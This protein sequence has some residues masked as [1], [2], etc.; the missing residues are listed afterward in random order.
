MYL[1]LSEYL[2]FLCVENSAPAND[3]ASLAPVDSVHGELMCTYAEFKFPTGVEIPQIHII[4]DGLS[5]ALQ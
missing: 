1:V 3:E 4:G 5:K 2:F